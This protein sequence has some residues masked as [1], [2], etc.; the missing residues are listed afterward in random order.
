[1]PSAN[2]WTRRRTLLFMAFLFVVA[3]LPRLAAIDR[4]I[5]PDELTW[6][7]RSVL[8]RE[9][10]R[11][12]QWA[13]TLTAG[14]PGVTTTWLGAVSMSL[15][16]A[17]QPA[18]RAAYEW[19]TKMAWLA[20]DN[21]A[22]FQQLATFL[23]GG[24]VAAAVVNSLGLAA[25]FPLLSRLYNRP[26]AV[27]ATLLLALDPFYAG[28]S[29]LLHVDGLMTTFV[30]LSLVSLGLVGRVGRW[31]M[32][33]FSGAMAGLAILSK[34]PALLLLPVAAL[35][36]FMQIWWP[37]RKAPPAS[38]SARFQQTV[39]NGAAWLGSCLLTMLVLWPALWSAPLSVFSLAGS[40][41]GRH[42]EEALRPTFF[43]GQVAFEHG[44]WFYPLN[45]AFRLS[46]VVFAG[47]LVAALMLVVQLVRSRRLPSWPTLLLTAWIILFLVGISLAAKKFDRYA[48]PVIPSL[49]ILSALGWWRLRL[50]LMR[51]MAGRNRSFNAGAILLLLLQALYLLRFTPYP[52]AAYN[53]L[54]GG[55]PVAAQV[56]TVGWGEGISAGGQWL[57]KQEGSGA[58]TA[59]ADS[60]PALAPFFA[61]QSTILDAGTLTT[62]NTVLLSLNSKQIDP[63]GFARIADHSELL[64]TVEYGGL[65]Q[66]WVFGN[67]NPQ[68]QPEPVAWETPLTFGAVV[69]L[70]AADP[71]AG[72]GGLVLDVLWGLAQP[73]MD[74]Y[75]VVVTVYDP[76]GNEWGRLETPLLNEVYFPPVHWEPDAQPHLRYAV[77]LPPAASPGEYTI[78]IA[79]FAGETGERL[80][81]RDSR[82]LFQG[83]T[84]SSE[85]VAVPIPAQPVAQDE[86]FVPFPSGVAWLGGDL[87]LLGTGVLPRAVT[88]GDVL[89]L[90]LFWHTPAG[91]LP[92]STPVAWQLG[93]SPAIEL[94]LSNQYP[95][96][97]WRAGETVQE[98]YLLP[99]SPTLP[100]GTYP[101]TVA[102]CDPDCRP[103]EI[104]QVQVDATDRNF[105]PPE[106]MD[107][108]FHARYLGVAGETLTLL[109]V[110]LP[111]DTVATGENL[112]L[113]L[114]WQM[115][116]RPVVDYT[117]FVHLL[118]AEGRI[119][120]QSDQWPGGL[121]ATLRAAGEVVRDEHRIELP[122]T[123]PAGEYAVIIG[124]YTAED[125]VRRP[126]LDAAGQPSA[127]DYIRL[128]IPISVSSPN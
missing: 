14:H 19:A 6:V 12:G 54:L 21:A 102:V 53:I 100:A 88:A 128:P 50:L 95:A 108:A 26:V 5:T 92:D 4:Y 111:A 44:P 89:P 125:G 3:L 1:M 9:A 114:H 40:N 109:G 72:D 82:G 41:A 65:E 60:L 101:L 2:T 75:S 116:D 35:Y 38:R 76:A 56:V 61:G 45:L 16:M 11:Q 126:V 28:L 124:L 84:F 86:V 71:A 103:Y 46:P 7:Y 120:S 127:E 57:N 10:L 31:R 87:V 48:L 77:N 115:G 67:P 55:P 104:G 78:Q 49:V 27:L 73:A 15:Q 113:V 18:G 91:N 110:D 64:H 121:P 83:V 20:P 29:G 22:A 79:L 105:T 37:D 119:V 30:A 32:P 34:S 43:L 99:I 85:M 42:I 33:L 58:Q 90:D 62:A 106:Q 97:S 123:V 51:E 74:D 93:N 70:W 23:T 96:G 17:V 122:A 94:P 80:P 25:L 81:L 59:A 66:A 24:R 47:L 68:P 118:D 107:V 112:P 117:V 52:L 36:L 8:F 39:K 69:Q 63:A 13:E 98:K